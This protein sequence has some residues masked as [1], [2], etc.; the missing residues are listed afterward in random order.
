MKRSRVASDLQRSSRVPTNTD[1]SSQEFRC[2][3]SKA[4][5]RYPGIL[6]NTEFPS[7][8]GGGFAADYKCRVFIPQFPHHLSEELLADFVRIGGNIQKEQSRRNAI[9]PL[10]F[11][12]YFT[13]EEA[14]LPFP[15]RRLPG[16]APK[17]FIIDVQRP[18]R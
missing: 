8:G 4:R 14:R 10:K 9:R 3:A 16:D 11:R 2:V 17:R 5:E 7:G 1:Q 6:E 12:S 18:A 13:R 15:R